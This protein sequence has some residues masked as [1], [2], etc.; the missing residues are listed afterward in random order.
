MDC[1][2][3]TRNVQP[4]TL[5]LCEIITNALKYSHPAGVPVRL[6]IRCEGQGNGDL[7]VTVSDDGVGLPESFDSAKD[8]GV[9]FQLIRS[10]TAEMGAKLDISSD[11]LG[12]TFRI[13]VPQMLIANARTA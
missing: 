7:Q 1:H 13:T 4:L 5:V 6:A 11:D 9:G 2:V 12:A 10:L 3:M 8:G